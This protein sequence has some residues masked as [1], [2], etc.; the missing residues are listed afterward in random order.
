MSRHFTLCKVG[1]RFALDRTRRVRLQ[2]VRTG[3]E[4]EPNRWWMEWNA[5]IETMAGKQQCVFLLWEDHNEQPHGLTLIMKNDTIEP[6]RDYLGCLGFDAIADL[7]LY[8]AEGVATASCYA[9]ASF[10]INVVMD[11]PN[12]TSLTG[13]AVPSMSLDSQGRAIVFHLASAN[14]N[15]ELP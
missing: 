3:D 2:S 6:I 7:I 11:I 12:F 13:G 1:L 5:S 9:G 14:C 4:V 10:S 8:V 15:P